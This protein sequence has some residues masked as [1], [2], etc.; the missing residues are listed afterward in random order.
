[1]LH[2]FAEVLM[3]AGKNGPVQVVVAVAQDEE[4]L[5][6]VKAAHDAG[7][8]DATLVGDATL[9]KPM[10]ARVGL[11]PDTKIVH[12][13]EVVQAAVRAASIV[14]EMPTGIL[15]KGLINSSEFLRAVLHPECGL[16]TGRLL[17]H[18][19]A[20]EVP[21]DEK[22]VFH[23]DGGMNIAPTLLEKKDILVSA[24][25]ALEALGIKLPKVAI[26]TAN[27]VVNPKMPAT[28]DALALVEMNRQ[29]VFGPA[30]LEGPISMDVALS[31]EAA[32]HKGIKSEISGQ[33]DLFVVPSI[34]AGNLLGKA[35]IYCAKA[36]SAGVI[37]G[38]TH[39]VVMVSRAD[40]ADAKLNSIALACCIASGQGAK[41]FN[42]KTE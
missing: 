18:L 17:C 34:E 3:R 19:A 5:R 12:E 38:A 37:L 4:A 7:L 2:N 39:P 9:I 40:S 35:L 8:A 21:G 20:F 29:G 10:L 32:E 1:M 27:E 22:L 16:R 25:L 14:K 30:L 41:C 6:A 13:P 15:M 36:K 11:A 23:T 24:L 28:V 26:L 33:V 31:R 42:P